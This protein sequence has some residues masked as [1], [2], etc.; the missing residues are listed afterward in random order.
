MKK[1]Y[2]ALLSILTI[3]AVIFWAFYS[4]MPQTIDKSEKLSEFSTAR[5]LKIVK[6]ISEKPHFVTSNNHENVANYLVSELK[7]LGLKTSFQEGFTLTEWGNLA[8]SKNIIATIKGSDS[9]KSLLIMSHYDSAPHSFSHGASDDATGIATILEGTRAFLNSNQKHKND[10][11]IL[12]SDAE[13]LGLN[14]AA[15]FVTKNKICKNVGLAINFEARGTSGPSFMLMEVN[16]GNAKM[17]EG[18][19][20]AN[21]KIIASNSLMYSIY[22]LLPN[23]TDLTVFRTH[24]QVQGFNFAFIDSHFNYHTQQDNFQNLNPK[25]LA[26]QGNYLMPLMKYFGNADLNN[27][28]SGEDLVYFSTPIGFINYPF[29]WVLPMVILA[30]ILFMFLMFLALGKRLISFTEVAKGFLVMI[31]SIVAV[32]TITYFGWQLVLKIYPQYADILQG[33]TYNGHDYILAFLMLS[34]SICFFVYSRLTTNNRNVFSYWIASILLWL[35]INFGIATALPGAGFLIFPVLSSLL[36]FGIYLLTQKNYWFLNLIFAMPLLIILVP[37]LELFP[38]GLGLKIL[39]GSCILLSLIFGLMLPIFGSFSKKSV[40]SLVFFIISMVFFIKAHLNADYTNNQP[41]PNSLLYFLDADA[42]KSF[43]LTYDNIPD[44]FTKTY[45]T[46][47]PKVATGFT[48][49][50]LFSKY[51]SRFTFMNTADNIEVSKPEISFIKDSLSG[52]FRFL[53]IKITPTRKVNRYDIFANEKMD[54][55]DFKS[56][57][58]N[59][60]EQK[61]KKLIRKDR[62]ILTYYVTNNMPLEMEFAINKKTVLDMDMLESSFDLITNP[63]FEIK[64]RQTWMMPKP[65]VLNDAVVL[66]LHI[67]ENTNYNTALSEEF[68]TMKAQEILL[69]SQK[70]SIR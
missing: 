67:Q 3:V 22:K 37:F 42:N 17:V 64:K 40:Y 57:G 63:A 69:K 70:D 38:V 51:D 9:S 25:S 10:I 43:W 16:K 27:L 26:Q 7:K 52:E 1:K 36:I 12:F 68:K 48:K 31:I 20:N 47:K 35:I 60:I 29:S 19:A 61:G 53:K 55:Y 24:G 66:K 54:F 15:L 62:K 33:F 46:D 34:L 56:N 14:G 4:L 65:F 28:N 59:N 8:Y 50:P 32:G 41:K 23:D 45:L 30:T 13:E 18:F 11:V 49:Y 58:V 21:P 6:K 5:A 2:P 44:E 39:F